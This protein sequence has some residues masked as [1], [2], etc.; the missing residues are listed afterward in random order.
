MSSS[1]RFRRMIDLVSTLA[2]PVLL[3][4]AA[5]WRP[6][7]IHAQPLCSISG[8]TVAL[9]PPFYSV[10]FANTFTLT[11]HDA[12]TDN[13]WLDQVRAT[14][15]AGWTASV[16]SQDTQDSCGHSV[17]FSVSGSGSNQI[18]FSSSA[19]GPGYDWQAVL[20]VTVPAGASGNQTVGW[21]LSGTNAG[22]NPH[23]IS[24]SLGLTPAQHT[25]LPLAARNYGERRYAII[26]GIADYQYI[27]DLDY[28][29]DDANSLY[30]ELLSEG[31][32]AADRVRLLLNGQAT[33]AAI[34]DAIVNWL[35]PRETSTDAVVIFFAGHGSR[36]SPSSEPDNFD[37][38]LIPYNFNSYANTA[39]RDDEL[40]G[41]LD[42]LESGRI[43]FIAD[44][45]FSGGL[46]GTAEAESLRC[47]CLPPLDDSGTDAPRDGGF[48]RHINQNG[49]LVLAAS[50]ENES[51]WESSTLKHGVYT[52]YLLQALET[53]SAD[54]RD[55]NGW[56][57]G[58]EAHNYLN[59]R[60]VSYT[61]N[62][63]H[64]QI[65]DAIPGEADLSRP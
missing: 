29:D 45:C 18:T 14:F 63:Q 16:V 39:I 52:H 37:E 55:A 8:S 13:E 57:S 65:S 28:P 59:P 15:P 43:I 24:D 34:Q 33:K 30:Q 51:S 6:G 25:Y 36:S 21:A 10:G 62:S 61:S 17:S 56:I 5:L 40:D 11:A 19:I 49:R 31:G 44:S 2:L 12:S 26:I 38:Y 58:E 64:P 54:T 46:I 20:S 32:F 47:R 48:I 22:A 27:N 4:L 42:T 35:D 50:A 7:A 9:S 41:W 53:S 23:D 60:V 3:I 1:Q